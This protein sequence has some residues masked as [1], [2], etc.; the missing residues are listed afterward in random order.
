MPK[1]TIEIIATILWIVVAI[2]AAMMVMFSAMM[3]D[4]PGSDQNPYLWLTVGSMVSYFPAM[5]LAIVG[6]WL[7]WMIRPMMVKTRVAVASL[8]LLSAA[9]TTL[10]FV[11]I[12]TLCDG[13][14]V[15]P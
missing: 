8:P 4:A 15:C 1:P 14:F 13:Q 2:P 9:G 5:F 12:M 10:G 3:F 6:G 7:L 11:L